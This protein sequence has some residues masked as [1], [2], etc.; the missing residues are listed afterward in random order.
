[1]YEADEISMKSGVTG[2]ELM[3]HAGEAVAD[4]AS[5]V[6]VQIGK[7]AAA[8]KSVLVLCGP[9]NNGGDGFV[10]AAILRDKG[11]EVKL[12]S[13]LPID[14]IKGDAL[15]YVKRWEGGICFDLEKSDFERVDLVVDALFGAGLSR[16][17]EGKVSQ[18]CRW[19][20]SKPVVSVDV[21]SGVCGDSGQV[22]GDVAFEA[23][24]G[25]SPLC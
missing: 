6:L 5:L 13:L 9:G 16:P 12:F 3:L 19:A 24:R 10:A 25:S 15:F 7:K 20:K 23:K 21:P 17:L 22:I 2:T 18:Y 14:A 4:A 8:V 11:F 1:M